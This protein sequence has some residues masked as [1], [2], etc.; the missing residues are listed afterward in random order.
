MLVP[1]ERAG[2]TDTAQVQGAARTVR[3]AGFMPRLIAQILDI[4]I[5]AVVFIPL[6]FVWQAQ[7]QPTKVD[8]NTNLGLQQLEQNGAFAAAVAL[9][10]VFYFAGSWNILGASPGMLTMGLR[11]VG[12]DGTSP[13]FI[14]AVTRY[15]FLLI[16]G[17]VGWLPMIT[18]KSKQGFHDA[19]ARTFVVQYV[20]AETLAM[21]EA[22]QHAAAAKQ[23]A[24]DA[25]AVNP[26]PAPEPPAPTF[27]PPAPPMPAVSSVPV[28]PAVTAHDP[29][30]P[31][32]MPAAP[33]VE[34][35]ATPEPVPARLPVEPYAIPF[36][37]AVA[38]NSPPAEPVAA[39]TE[40]M[41]AVEPMPAPEPP[42]AEPPP[43]PEPM[44]PAEPTATEPAT[45]PGWMPPP[46]D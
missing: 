2:Q 39:P 29:F 15:V 12:K 9:I 19:F 42:P 7:L 35:Q 18:N 44:P 1:G 27:A 36:A 6:Y 45:P 38:V 13:S 46:P 34:P 20:D 24:A 5:L 41:Q 33:P 30:A 8:V 40:P 3:P 17:V 21:E 16:T 22:R 4:S 31:P 11:V 37:P 28:Q 14:Q 43:P 23:Q 32:P 10:S 26:M 25:A